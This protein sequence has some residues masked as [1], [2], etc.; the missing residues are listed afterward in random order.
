MKNLLIN[1]IVAIVCFTLGYT[2]YPSINDTKFETTLTNK[3]NTHN[4]GREDK[5]VVKLPKL[6][7]KI[8]TNS[9]NSNPPEL[10]EST[11]E[12]NI[13][14]NKAN[15]DEQ[16]N[17]L[18]KEE[19]IDETVLVLQKE[20]EEW[21]VEHKDRINELVTSI[22]SSESSEHMK[23]QISQENDFLSEPSIEQDAAEDDNWAYNME[24]HLKV[25]IAQ[26]ELSDKF[27]LVNLSCKQLMCD[28]LGIEKEGGSWCKL[29]I[30][31]LQ[32]APMAE[33]PNGNDDPKSVVYME[34]DVAVVYDQIR[35][36]SS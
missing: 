4:S 9:G 35:F 12:K 19:I 28:I 30:S 15:E 33:F 27:E 34:G 13:E 8:K 7:P 24:Q 29:Y 26:H 20:L 23:S 21:S 11:Q 16:V 22:M 32:N 14:I 25:L 2:L 5:S 1:T 3:V 10:S 36:K 18:E 6:A 31:L 17:L